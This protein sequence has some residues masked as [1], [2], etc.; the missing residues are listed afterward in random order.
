M[1]KKKIKRVLRELEGMAHNHLY[2]LTNLESRT[3]DHDTKIIELHRR[4]KAM[5]AY[6]QRLFDLEKSMAALRKEVG[7]RAEAERPWR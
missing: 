7:I 5:E 4:L 1:G 2:R 3:G 6:S